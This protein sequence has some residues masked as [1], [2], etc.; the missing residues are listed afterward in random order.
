MPKLLLIRAVS[1]G[2]FLISRVLHA[3]EFKFQLAAATDVESRLLNTRMD[4]QSKL[5]NKAHT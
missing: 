3:V 5:P 2:W 4:G 1:L